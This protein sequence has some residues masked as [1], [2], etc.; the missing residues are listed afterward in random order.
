MSFKIIG[1]EFHKTGQ[2]M[3]IFLNCKKV[4]PMRKFIGLDYCHI[5]II[6]LLEPRRSRD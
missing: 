6:A 3:E 1:R 2:S 5:W 4:V